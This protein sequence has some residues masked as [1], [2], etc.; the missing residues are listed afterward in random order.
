MKTKN[1]AAV[2][3]GKLGKGISR[4]YTPA[5]RA[6]LRTRLAQA[7]SERWIKAPARELARRRL[8]AAPI[9]P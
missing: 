9:T 4:H 7:R 2:A 6:A 1:P 3:L 8:E 5:Q